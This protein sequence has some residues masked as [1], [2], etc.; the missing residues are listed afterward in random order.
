MHDIILYSP[1]FI[2]CYTPIMGKVIMAKHRTAGIIYLSLFVIITLVI[3]VFAG[4]SGDISSSQSGWVADILN[5]VLRFF[6]IN[7][8]GE[9]FDIFALVVR[10]VLGH[11][12]IFLLDGVFGYLALLKLL[13]INRVW[14][15]LSI[16]TAA[17]FGVAGISELIQY[18]T[19]GR[20][21]N[22]GDVGIDVAGALIGILIVFLISSSANE[23]AK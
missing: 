1:A 23:K 2:Y 22:W 16:A 13:K 4:L 18:F 19:S 5:S 8:S 20:S 6:S 15:G 11:F 21:A 17:M 7:L 3:F 14:L 12:L 9:Q 10:K